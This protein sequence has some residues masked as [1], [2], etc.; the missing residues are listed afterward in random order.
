MGLVEVILGFLG[1]STIIGGTVGFFI[2]RYILKRDRIRDEALAEQRRREAE[3]QEQIRQKTEALERQ[4]KATQLGV[5]AL[6][7]DRLLQAFRHYIEKG[8]ADY[9]DRANLENMYTQY[10]ALGPNSVMEDLYEEFS[11]LPSTP[12]ND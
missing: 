12:Q 6:L 1:T 5:Q 9:N 2:Q 11:R 7:R 3:E 8:W 10:E 4:N